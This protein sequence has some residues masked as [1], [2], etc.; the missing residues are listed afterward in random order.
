[1]RRRITI[2]IDDNIEDFDAIR[3]ILSVVA[4]GRV[5]GPFLES[6]CYQTVFSD[7]IVVTSKMRSGKV[8]NDRFLV[9]KLNRNEDFKY[10]NEQRYY[11]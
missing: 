8:T 7:D 6:Y 1:M 11:R 3:H 4:N 10:L 9:T 5:S 2:T